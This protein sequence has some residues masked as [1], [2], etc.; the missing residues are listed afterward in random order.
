VKL[1]LLGQSLHKERR[2]PPFYLPLVA[3]L[4]LGRQVLHHLSHAPNTWRGVL[5]AWIPRTPYG[6]LNSTK[7]FLIY[8]LIGLCDIFEVIKISINRYVILY[9]KS[10]SKIFL[11]CVTC[12]IRGFTGIL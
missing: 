3:V 5:E 9:L 11:D 7:Y 2:F 8:Y 4:E 1:K 6:T 10:L 12:N